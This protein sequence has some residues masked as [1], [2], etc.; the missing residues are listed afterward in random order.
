MKFFDRFSGKLIFV[1]AVSLWGPSQPSAEFL[2]L[3][4][5]PSNSEK[6]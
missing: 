2:E 1:R 6:F 5:A 4:L 3:G